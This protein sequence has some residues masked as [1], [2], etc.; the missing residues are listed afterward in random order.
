MKAEVNK[1]DIEKSDNIPTDLNNLKT[2]IDNLDVDKFKTVPVNLKKINDVLSKEIVSN[3]K[4]QQ[5]KYK[6]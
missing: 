1:L 6:R 2:K 3:Q 4:V 5:T